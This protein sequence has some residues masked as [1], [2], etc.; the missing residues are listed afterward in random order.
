MLQLMV[1]VPEPLE[2]QVKASGLSQKQLGIMMTY[3]L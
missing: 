1:E 2:K 3:F